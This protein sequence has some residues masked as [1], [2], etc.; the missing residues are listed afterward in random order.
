MKISI[1]TAT[2]NSAATV[3]D[4]LESVFNQTHAD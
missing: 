4:T 1:I 2:F 3:A